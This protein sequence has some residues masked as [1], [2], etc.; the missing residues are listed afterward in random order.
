MN[1]NLYMQQNLER[2]HALTFRVTSTERDLIR[3]KMNQ[4]NMKNLRAYLLKM[5]IDGRII[6]IDLT[7]VTEMNRLLGNVSNNINQIARHVNETSNIY[8]TD[9]EN[10]RARQEEI[11]IQQKEILRLISGAMDA[12]KSKIV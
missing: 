1:G 9:I 10:I 11:W 2:N 12:V 4:V 6:S 3:H 7:G 8:P 5:A